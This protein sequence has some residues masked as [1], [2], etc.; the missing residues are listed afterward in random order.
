MHPIRKQRLYVVLAIVLSASVAAALIF[1]ALGQNLNLFYTPTQVVSG[2]APVEKRIRVGGMVKE[3]S[4][5]RSDDSLKVSFVV[6]DYAADT[7]VTYDK[8][9]PDMFAEGEGV[10]ATGVLDANGVMT[11]SEVLAKHDET[12]MPPE[13]YEALEKSGKTKAEYDAAATPAGSD[14]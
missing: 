13:V 5:V 9:L 8:L 11:A 14:Y 1:V 3:G 6:T 12:Y 7:T 10:V 4:V 2:E